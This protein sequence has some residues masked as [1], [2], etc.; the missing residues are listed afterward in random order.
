MR[1]EIKEEKDELCESAISREVGKIDNG[2]VVT[3][4]FNQ[5][6]ISFNKFKAKERLLAV[7]R[8]KPEI[9]AQMVARI[10]FRGFEIDLVLADMYS[11]K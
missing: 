10:N 7:P 8:S 9:A 4:G 1:Q 11:R 3:A 2:I 6:N 5:C